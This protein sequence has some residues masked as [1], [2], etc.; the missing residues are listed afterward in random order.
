MT[1]PLDYHLW[2]L[3]MLPG[4]RYA[5]QPMHTAGEL[6]VPAFYMPHTV[7]A[8]VA[9]PPLASEAQTLRYANV[10]LLKR[11]TEARRF[12]LALELIN[13]LVV[14]GESALDRIGRGR[15]LARCDMGGARNRLSGDPGNVVGEVCE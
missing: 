1:D 12:D 4:T 7:G 11:V 2:V 15:S 3:A 10:K 6:G 14:E 9:P 8:V 5:V 13:I